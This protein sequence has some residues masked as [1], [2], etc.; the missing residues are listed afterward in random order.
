MF[1]EK[2]VA[3]HI[4]DNY[5]ILNQ[6]DHLLPFDGKT[7][8]ERVARKIHESG[9]EGSIMLEIGKNRRED[10]KQMAYVEF[11]EKAA[12]LAKKIRTMTDGK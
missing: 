2:L 4:H 10:Y 12:M 11:V 5:G 9:Y 8:F 7:D 3:L 6:D 1:G